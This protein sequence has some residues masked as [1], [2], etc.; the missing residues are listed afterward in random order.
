MLDTSLDSFHFYFLV[1]VL[2]GFIL[3]LLIV[4]Q[5]PLKGYTFYFGILVFLIS[6]S[7]LHGVLEESIHAFNTRFLF[8]MEY[9]FALGPITYFHI[10]YIADPDFR[11][12]QR[13]LL[14]FIPSLLFDVMLFFGFFGYAAMNEA[15]AE[16][17]IRSIQMLFLSVALLFI[18][19]T[20][21]YLYY[22][23]RTAFAAEI[24]PREYA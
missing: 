2:Q 15:W 19:Y 9:G 14:H 18:V 22:M 11:F 1:A 5:R 21:L 4:F 8:P 6:L 7:P 17:N 24:K 10:R 13:H 12:Q 3:S 23:W 16:T 20:S